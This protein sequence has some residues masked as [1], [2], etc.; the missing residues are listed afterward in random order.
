MS[1]KLD[2]A[3]LKRIAPGVAMV[4]LGGP[5]FLFMAMDVIMFLVMQGSRPEKSSQVFDL[6]M[7][8]VLCG[9]AGLFTAYGVRKIWRELKK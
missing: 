6:S 7:E 9:F 4:A 3:T 1:G 8:I 2:A 5:V